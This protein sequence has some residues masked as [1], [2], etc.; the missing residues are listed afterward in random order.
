MLEEL[1]NPEIPIIKPNTHSLIEQISIKFTA[2]GKS[3]GF[4]VKV[5]GYLE[6]GEF[7]KDDSSRE[8]IFCDD[9]EVTSDMKT[10]ELSPHIISKSKEEQSSES[11]KIRLIDV[12]N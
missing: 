8:Q 6:N 7:V 3:S 4:V 2:D 5:K 11:L 9:L 10:S 12:K 1:D